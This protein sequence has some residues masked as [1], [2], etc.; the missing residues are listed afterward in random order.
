MKLPFTLFFYILFSSSVYAETFFGAGGGYTKFSIDYTS[1]PSFEFEDQVNNG[2]IFIGYEFDSLKGLAKFETSYDYYGD[3][4]PN[5]QKD[6]L[7]SFS[8]V[9]TPSIEIANGT[10]ITARLGA[11]RWNS[12]ISSENRV[13]ESQ[14]GSAVDVFY[15]ISFE[16]PL[17]D[18]LSIRFDYD[19][20]DID[21][22]QFDT[23]M[24]LLTLK[25]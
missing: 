15:G 23:F 5:I 11:F 13:V 24:M 9:W 8:V 2:K 22:V 19:V 1:T 7:S 21:Y 25:F 6:V 17:V 12:D 14:G 16:T 3:W 20:H 10:F 18:K 4:N